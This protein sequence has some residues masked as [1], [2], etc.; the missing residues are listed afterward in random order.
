MQIQFINSFVSKTSAKLPLRIFVTVPFIMHMI[1]VVAWTG[2]ISFRKEQ[3]AVHDIAAQLSSEISERIKQHI[4]DYLD[5]PHSIHQVTLSAIQSGQLNLEKF[6]QM[7]Y[8]F[9]QQLK[10]SDSVSQVYFGNEKGDFIGVKRLNNGKIVVK[11]TEKFTTHERS[12]YLLDGQGKQT[13]LIEKDKFDPRHRPWYKEA[14]KAHKSKWSQI[15]ISIDN[16]LTITPFVPVYNYKGTLLGVLGIDLSLSEI[17]DFLGSI[18]ISRTGE[19]FIIERSGAIVATSTLE[20]PFVS[21]NNKQERL[22]AINSSEPLIKFTANHLLKKFGN[23]SNIHT[24]NQFFFEIN[25][26]WQLVE[27]APLKNANGLNWLIVVVIPEADFMDSLK[28]RVR[29]TIL[30]CLLGLIVAIWAGFQTCRWI[31]KPILTLNTAAKKLSG[32]EWD[33]PL[34]IDRSAELV[35]L[36]N[37]FNTMADQLKQSLNNLEDKNAKLQYLNKL[38]DEF[39]ANTSHELRTPLHA[40]IN[41]AESLVDGATGTLSYDTCSNLAMIISSGRRLSHLVDDILDF[42]K[43][44]NKNIE[45][46]IKSVG[47]REIVEIVCT[48]SLPLASQ[49][50]LQLINAISSNL[51]TVAGDENRLQQILYNLVGNAIKFTEEGTVEISAKTV[52]NNYLAITVKDTGI[53]IPKNKL[54]RIFEFFEQAENSPEREYGGA[55]L[56]LAITKKLVELHKGEI[57]VESTVGIGSE[58]TFTLPIFQGLEESRADKPSFPSRSA[59]F[60]NS[61]SSEV[62]NNGQQTIL[63]SPQQAE[64]TILIVDDE[65]VNRQVLIN[66]LSLHNYAIVQAANGQQT[67]AILEGGLIP[68]LILLDVMMPRMTG[69]VVCQ[70]IRETWPANQLPIMMLTAKNQVSDL[71]AGLEAGANDYLS[72]PIEKDEL[73]ARVKTLINIKQLQTEKAQIRRTLERYLPK[74]VVNQVLGPEGSKLG[75]ERRKITILTSDIRGF[76]AQSER[77]SPE[78]VIK[79]INLYLGYMTDVITKYQGTIDEFMGDGI[80]VLFGAPMAREDDA[81][82]AVACAIAMQLTMSTINEKMKELNLPALGM[83]IGIN[84]GEVVVGNIGS[85]TRCKYGVVGSQVNLTYRIE[86]YTTGGEIFI[87]EGTLKELGSTVRIDGKKQVLAKGVKEPFTIYQ[88]GGISGE[89]NLFLPQEEEVFLPLPAEIPIQYMLL[90]GKHLSNT[91]LCGSLVQLSAKGAKVRCG[92]GEQQ[93]VPDVLSNLKL[94]LLTPN[95]QL[96]ISEDVYAKVCE[97]PAEMGSFYIHFTAKP[98]EIEA[99]LDVLYKLIQVKG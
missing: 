77:L 39:L 68:D 83:G 35:E 47:I 38:K 2:Y 79:I 23:F 27:V 32:G 73:L 46:Q 30:I 85:E 64:F 75:G 1:T 59:V 65:P 96:E 56:G 69:Y 82:R 52:D 28:A 20:R 21:L 10:Q 80:L 67:L 16:S 74:E 92:N 86:S 55:G 49:R 44:K 58:F 13:E 26:K 15:Y 53:G 18:G 81:E 45:L 98:P 37:S 22:L 60:F 3:E 7:Q 95:N 34:D 72:K 8:Y 76:T 17:S 6:P 51:P 61:Q 93:G 5:R 24:K 9:W 88:I 99:R 43:L 11:V 29:F 41:L 84:T 42:S 91:P 66:Y 12:G 54:D 63:L 33:Q 62:S 14:K 40:I 31:V 71:V 89:Y 94:N 87:S 36:A 97:K 70:K 78:E 50:H 90:E 4:Q 48:L 25:G 19:A 57:S